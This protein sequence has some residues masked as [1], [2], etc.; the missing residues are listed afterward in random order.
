M[1]F[2]TNGKYFIKKVLNLLDLVDCDSDFAIDCK[3]TAICTHYLRYLSYTCYGI[4]LLP[5]KI[6]YVL[7]KIINVLRRDAIFKEKI[8]NTSYNFHGD[9]EKHESCWFYSKRRLQCTC[10]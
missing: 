7:L 9:V 6:T 10:I 2:A 5:S 4:A 8:L 1:R 3:A